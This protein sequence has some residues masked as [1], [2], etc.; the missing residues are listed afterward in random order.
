MGN[1]NVVSSVITLDVI[2]AI[3]NDGCFESRFASVVYTEQE[4]GNVIVAET[5]K[6]LLHLNMDYGK[7][8]AHDLR[9]LKACPVPESDIEKQAL[10]EVIESVRVSLETGANPA[11]TLA[12][13]YEHLSPSIAIH[14][15]MV[16]ITGYCI[17]RLPIVEGTYRI[18]KHKP[19]TVAKDR[20]RTLCKRSRWRTLRVDPNMLHEVKANKHT[21]I[22]L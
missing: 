6:Y 9:T 4:K 14:E 10:A 13:Y 7:V 22:V 17:K 5:S 2:R 11:Y 3:F 16:Y 19:L 15:S 8:L 21:I 20:Y 12:G 18:V 1:T